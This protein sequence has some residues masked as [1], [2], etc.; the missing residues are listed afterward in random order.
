GKTDRD[1]FDERQARDVAEHDQEAMRSRQPIHYESRHTFGRAVRDVA[2]SKF[3]YVS[4]E[5]DLL[6]IAGITRAITEMKRVEE[7]ERRRTR[8]RIAHQAALLALAQRGA[9]DFAAGVERILDTD[10]ETLGVARVSFWSFLDHPPTI[11]SHAMR[12]E[13][14]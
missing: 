7:A 5:G 12:A 3:A 9:G 8:Q 2:T 4:S 14:S 13:G 1:L 6:G 11:V 10:G